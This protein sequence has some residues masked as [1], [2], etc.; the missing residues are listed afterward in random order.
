V[1]KIDIAK[2]HSHAKYYFTLNPT[3]N[4]VAASVED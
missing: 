1:T 2:Q 3:K 4:T